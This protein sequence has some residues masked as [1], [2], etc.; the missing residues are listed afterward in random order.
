MKQRVSGFLLVSGVL[1]AIAIGGA[2]SW[3]TPNQEHFTRVTGQQGPTPTPGCDPGLSHPCPIFSSEEAVARAQ[4]LFAFSP[5]GT[6]VRML[7]FQTVYEDWLDLEVPDGDDPDAPIWL[8]ALEGSG[9]TMLGVMPPLLFGDLPSGVTLADRT[10][11]GAYAGFEAYGGELRLK[12][13]IEAPGVSI[14]SNSPY[15]LANIQVLMDEQIPIVTATP[16]QFE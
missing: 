4:A 6:T 5:T 9:L 12:G 8:V 10:V 11:A 7:S 14:D 2:T 3:V 15:L 13:V 1:A 16:Y